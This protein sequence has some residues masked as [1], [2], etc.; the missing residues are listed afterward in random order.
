MNS[1][2]EE[3]MKIILA[4]ETALSRQLALEVIDKP[5]PRV[6]MIFIPI[7]FVF[8]FWKLKEYESGLKTFAESHL[9]PRRRT[10]EVVF[11]AQETD[12]PVNIEL[13]TDQVGGG[14][15]ENA[16]ALCAEWLTMLTGHF[17]L[18]I[19]TVGDSY[20]ALIRAGY[21]DKAKYLLFCH[22]LGK[23]ETAFNM[24]LL[25][26]IDGDSTDLHQVTETMA[27]GLYKLRCKEAEK[28]FS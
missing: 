13:L 19:A 16:R 25:P 14:M 4:N 7:F 5:V 1:S 11:A 17:Q 8:Y 23:A 22:Q 12:R 27:A 21:G 9:V 18:L 28:I 3:K 10:L 15:Q 20:P 26:A 2:I 24:A 6:W